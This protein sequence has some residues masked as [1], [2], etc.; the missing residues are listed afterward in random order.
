[1]D[2]SLEQGPS[3]L[4]SPLYPSVEALRA[5]KQHLEPLEPLSN[6]PRIGRVNGTPLGPLKGGNL[7]RESN[8]VISWLRFP[9]EASV[10]LDDRGPSHGRSRRKGKGGWGGPLV[11]SSEPSIPPYRRD[12]WAK[13]DENNAHL[14]LSWLHLPTWVPFSILRSGLLRDLANTTRGIN[15]S[16]LFVQFYLFSF[17]FLSS[18]FYSLER[19]RRESRTIGRYVEIFT[20]YSVPSTL[21]RWFD[22]Y[23]NYWNL[24]H[25]FVANPNK[26]TIYRSRCNRLLARSNTEELSFIRFIL[27]ENYTLYSSQ[28]FTEYEINRIRIAKWERRGADFY[29]RSRYRRP[30]SAD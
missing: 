22:I 20:K 21:L 29:V 3:S 23:I 11:N 18:F 4:L 26:R 14:T 5:S 15:I 16:R 8:Y 1:M 19:V 27:F 7:P 17:L 13:P 9:E 6:Y 28:T 30:F 24:Y 10:I 25:R 2:D 12:V